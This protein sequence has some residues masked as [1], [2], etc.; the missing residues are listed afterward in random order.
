MIA[1]ISN[2]K[3]SELSPDLLRQVNIS[4]DQI[5]TITIITESKDIQNIKTKG[6]QRKIKFLHSGKM[7]NQTG[8]TDI[9]EHHDQ[10]LYEADPHNES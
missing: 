8:E 1:T 10:Y 5:I 3:G 7:K 9:A 2:I 4:P 6:E